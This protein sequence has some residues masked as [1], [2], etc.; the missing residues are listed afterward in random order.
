MK[1]GWKRERREGG[2]IGACQGRIPFLKKGPFMDGRV[3][4]NNKRGER[5][6]S[7]K[8][9]RS[10]IQRAVKVWG[11]YETSKE[12]RFSEDDHADPE[13]PT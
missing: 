11:V 8:V 4:S 9:P 7:K 5:K 13:G 10:R 1:R 12:E 3:V 6:E 2:Q